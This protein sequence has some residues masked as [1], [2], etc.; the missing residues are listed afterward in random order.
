MANAIKTNAFLLIMKLRWPILAANTI[1]PMHVL[2]IL[3]SRWY[4]MIANVINTMFFV[5]ADYYIRLLIEMANALKA[6]KTS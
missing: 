5:V 4:I 2:P 3:I 1:T 6:S